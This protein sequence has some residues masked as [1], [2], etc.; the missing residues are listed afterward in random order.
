MI[1]TYAGYLKD[2]ILEMCFLLNDIKLGLTAC[3]IKF[4]FILKVMICFYII[5]DKFLTAF[6]EK[7]VPTFLLHIHLCFRILIVVSEIFFFKDVR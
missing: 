5:F 2:I 1:P 6:L 4:K 3:S 7:Y